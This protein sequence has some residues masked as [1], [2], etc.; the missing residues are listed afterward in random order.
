MSGGPVLGGPVPDLAWAEYVELVDRYIDAGMTDGLPVIPP[1]V[2]A[3]E[4]M[5]AATARPPGE[6]LGVAP[7]RYQEVTVRD[8][9]INA[10]LAGCLPAYLRRVRSLAARGQQM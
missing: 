9:A 1:H 2:D 10:V 5:L 8:V 7:P 4:A 6:V 3:V